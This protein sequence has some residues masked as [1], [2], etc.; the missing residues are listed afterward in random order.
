MVV[1][2]GKTNIM[3]VSDNI[4]YKAET[5]I[6]DNNGNEITGVDNMRVLG[7]DFSSKPTVH[8][9]VDGVR[10]RVRQKYWML[11]HLKKFGMSSS[12]LVSIYSS[13]ILPVMDYCDFVYHSMLTD[14]MDEQLEAAQA[15][16]L[17]TILGSGLSA[18]KMRSETGLKTMRDRR[19]EHADKFARKAANSDRFC[20][21]FPKRQGR[22]S[23]RLA[24]DEYEERFARLDRLKNSPLFFMRRRM[25]GKAGKSYGERNRIYRQT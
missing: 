3:C 1:N 11:R 10:K 17:R 22:R 19:V 7:F 24:G 5:Y 4:N 21:W 25:N 8:R 16:A 14:E 13:M 20:H 23:G 18:R 9:H 6:V 2:E 12:D 15:G